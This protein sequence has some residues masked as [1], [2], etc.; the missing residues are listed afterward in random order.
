MVLN[1]EGRA[2]GQFQTRIRPVEQRHMRLARVGG[3][4]LALDREAVVHAGDLDQAVG[5]ALDRVVRAAVA[6]VHLGGLGADRQTQQLMAQADAEQRL[7]GVEQLADHRHRIFA[8]RRRIAGAVGQEDAVRVQRHHI[9]VRSGG[10]D[11]RH[12]RARLNQVAEDVVLA[13]IIDRD[14]VWAILALRA[15]IAEA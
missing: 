6:L 14:D 3:Q 8:G 12:L 1:R 4:R 2:V 7:A 10:G 5:Q 9:L 15:C 11:H 13:A